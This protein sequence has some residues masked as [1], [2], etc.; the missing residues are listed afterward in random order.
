MH[1]RHCPANVASFFCKFLGE[2][3]HFLLEYA[4]GLTKR[5]SEFTLQCAVL[6]LRGDFS[7]SRCRLLQALGGLIAVFC[8]IL[9]R[10]IID[11]NFLCHFFLLSLDVY[12]NIHEWLA[13]LVM[14]VN[15]LMDLLGSITSV[16]QGAYQSLHGRQYLAFHFA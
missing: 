6:H 3:I 1:V 4:Q 8:H 10:R 5:F 2:F 12:F 13:F 9:Q 16:I 11:S 15:D 14:P 7:G